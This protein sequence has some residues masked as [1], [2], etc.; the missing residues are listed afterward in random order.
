MTGTELDDI[1]ADNT[2]QIE[3]QTETTAATDGQQ[4]DE[5]GRF[6]PKVEAEAA[7][8]AQAH[9]DTAQQAD[10]EAGRVPQQALHASREKERE[11]RQEAETLRQQIAEMRGQIQLLSQRGQAP[12]PKPAPPA[13]PDFWENP[14]VYLQTGVQEALSPVQ[15][16][17]Q[18]QNERFSRFMAVQ[19]HG[20]DAVDAA[21]AA[22]E[23]ELS[24]L[25]P[26]HQAQM[27]AARAKAADPYSEMVAWYKQKQTMETVGNDPNAW[28]EAEMEKRLADPAYQAKLLERIR[29]TAAGNTNRSN[30]VTNLPPSLNRL[31]A[32][33]NA[34]G[35]ADLSDAGLFASAL[36]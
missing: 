23:A 33:G 30:P 24:K 2:P 16:Q 29:T 19:A 6:A 35:E 12:E 20:K 21:E 34:P 31:A 10:T 4:R 13:K 8:A 25:P 7:P 3:Q 9:V 32:G 15:Q 1:L 14:D 27:R 22:V 26:D 18:Q 17:L 36:R 28:L 11:A 5:H